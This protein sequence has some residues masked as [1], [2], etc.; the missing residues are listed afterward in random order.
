MHIG[1]SFRY[2]TAGELSSSRVHHGA[3]RHEQGNSS[4]NPERASSG[5]G[6]PLSGRPLGVDGE[7]LPVAFQQLYLPGAVGCMVHIAHTGQIYRY[8]QAMAVTGV[9][10]WP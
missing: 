7:P 9:A 1:K 3:F 2:P 6:V 5:T 8:R 10:S 4:L